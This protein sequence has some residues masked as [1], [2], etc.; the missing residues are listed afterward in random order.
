MTL[1]GDAVLRSLKST[2]REEGK[3][4]ATHT[5]THAT[6]PHNLHRHSYHVQPIER[7][8]HSQEG[9]VACTPPFF[10]KPPQESPNPALPPP[11]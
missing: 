6:H 7:D 2:R 5:Y 3:V 10:A 11:P 1:F 8:R 4:K 9:R